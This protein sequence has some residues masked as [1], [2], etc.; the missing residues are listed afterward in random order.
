MLPI[1]TGTDSEVVEKVL[2]TDNWVMIGIAGAFFLVAV[3]ALYFKNRK[4][5]K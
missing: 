1:L 3:V 5:R 4:K 2:T